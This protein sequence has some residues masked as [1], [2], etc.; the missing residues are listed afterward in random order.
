MRYFRPGLLVFVFLLVSAF[1]SAQQS[2]TAPPP[3]L[4]QALAALTGGSP[5]TDVTMTG[6]IT[7]TN[8]SGTQSGTIT[9]VATASGQSQVVLDLPAGRNTD[10]RN[11]S[12]NPRTGSWTGPDGTSHAYAA[13]ELMGPSPAWFYPAFIVSS[14]VSPNCAASYV[15]QEIRQGA[16]VQHV[17][18]TP[19]PAVFTPLPVIASLRSLPPHFV[20][21][22]NDLY[23]DPSSLLPTALVRLISSRGPVWRRRYAPEEI[24]FSDYRTVE[25]RPAAFHIQAYLGSVLMDTQLSSISFNTGAVI[26]AN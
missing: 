2:T 23:L 26:A 9:M 22:Q 5:V 18:I 10:I 13:T 19:N 15:G 20:L 3:I 16:T 8:A 6:T 11:Y 25:G 17:S 14:A 1:L 4:Q 12:A 24:R 7:V 21:G